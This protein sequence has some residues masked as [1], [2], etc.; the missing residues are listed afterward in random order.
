MSLL[1]PTKPP[2][3][4]RDKTNNNGI[5]KTFIGLSKDEEK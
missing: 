2:T 5:K 1:K 4:N 3:P